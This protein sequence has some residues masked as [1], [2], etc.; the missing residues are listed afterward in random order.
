MRAGLAA[1]TVTPGRTA[2]DVSRTTPAMAAVS[3]TCAH[4]TAGR[5]E[6][7]TRN[8]DGTHESLVI[9]GLARCRPR[10][11]TADLI[12]ETGTS[13]TAT[14]SRQEHSLVSFA[15]TGAALLPATIERLGS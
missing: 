6:Q 12:S 2:P 7:E 4:A 8:D 13:I 9:H 1:S 15:K 3:D 10:R 14:I 5:Q 11:V